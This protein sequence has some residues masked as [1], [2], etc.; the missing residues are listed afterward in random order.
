MS[1]GASSQVGCLIWLIFLGLEHQYH[2]IDAP[3]LAGWSWTIW[4]D[5]ALMGPTGGT[6]AFGARVEQ[7][8]VSLCSDSLCGDRLGKAWPASTRL[9]LIRA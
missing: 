4:E 3:T 5:M 6:M 9:K 1:D 2:P 8:P 7:F